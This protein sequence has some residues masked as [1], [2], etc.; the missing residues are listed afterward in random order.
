MCRLVT[1]SAPCAGCCGNFWRSGV[2]QL[3]VGARKEDVE[4]RQEACTVLARYAQTGG[5]NY[6]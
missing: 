3:V 4:R 5:I 6:S 2:R 1:S